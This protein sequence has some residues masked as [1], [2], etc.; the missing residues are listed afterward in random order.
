[1]YMQKPPP[2]RIFTPEKENAIAARIQGDYLAKGMLFTDMDF[3]DFVLKQ[4]IHKYIE[5]P[6]VYPLH[7]N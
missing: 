3:R 6:D 4:Y 7:F 1:M 2:N 5:N